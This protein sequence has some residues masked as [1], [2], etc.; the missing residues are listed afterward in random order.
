MSDFETSLAVNTVD[1]RAKLIDDLTSY[2]A[3]DALNTNFYKIITAVA[4]ILTDTDHEIDNTVLDTGIDECRDAALFPNFGDLCGVDIRGDLNWDYDNYRFFLKILTEAWTLYGST[5]WGMRRVVQVATGVSPMLREHYKYAGWIL[6]KYVLGSTVVV[7]TGNYIWNSVTDPSF[8]LNDIYGIWPQKQTTVWVCGQGGVFKSTNAGY[9]WSNTIAP[10][11]TYYAIRGVNAY[12]TW[13][14]GELGGV[15]II[16]RWNF[17]TGWSSTAV[18][19]ILRGIWLRTPTEGFAVGDNGSVYYWNGS[20]WT[21]VASGVV[22]DLYAVTGVTS[23]CYYIVG[24]NSVVLKYVGGGIIVDVSLAAPGINLRALYAL[25][26]NIV[27]VC[28]ENGSIYY[29][30]NGGTT[31]TNIVGPSGD[32]FY[33][34]WVSIDRQ[35]IYVVGSNGAFYSSTDGGTTW[36]TLGT[37]EGSVATFRAL[38]VGPNGTMG[39]TCGDDGVV[40]RRSGQS[41]GY[42]L[43]DG[44]VLANGALLYG[45]IL[46]S[47]A[48]RQNGVDVLLWNIMDYDLTWKMI[49]DIKPAH[50]KLFPVIVYPF[51]MDYYYYYDYEHDFYVNRQGHAHLLQDIDEGGCI[52]VNGREY[53]DSMSRI[54]FGANDLYIPQ[55]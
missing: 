34:I 44:T 10:A 55:L 15:G 28:G 53:G 36:I 52:V 47:R 9:T 6:G 35:T 33:S 22:D 14:C 32:H 46:E 19:N 8:L 39:Y 30:T 45:T 49:N 4:D 18:A 40:L 42:T 13:V 48:L 26:N 5:A 31:W 3:K 27:Y 54:T 12:D 41:P 2:Y 37:Y 17:V 20:S 24:D 11:A 29:T 7:Q 43:Y 1:I 51:I 50:I 25:S 16:S 23:N 21:L 38:S